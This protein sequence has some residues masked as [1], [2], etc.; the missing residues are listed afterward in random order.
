MINGIDFY[1]TLIL[2]IDLKGNRQMI[3]DI[4]V[5]LNQQIIGGLV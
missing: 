2:D 3:D 5:W 4:K 1:F